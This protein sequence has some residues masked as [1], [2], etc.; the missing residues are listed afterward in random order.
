MHREPSELRIC[1]HQLM[2]GIHAPVRFV[3]FEPLLGPM[4]G[5]NLRGIAWAIVGGESG[6]KARPMQAD[7]AVE[8]KR[9]RARDDVAFFFKQ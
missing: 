2:R 7:W 6:P 8:I 9:V 1:G 3:S 4:E 5:L